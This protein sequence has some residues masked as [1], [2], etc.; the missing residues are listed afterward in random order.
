[1]PDDRPQRRPRSL[2]GEPIDLANM[3]SLGVRS[4]AV[5]CPTCRHET[6]LNVNSYP[7]NMTV[8]S[9]APRMVCTCCG[10]IGADARLNWKEQPERESLTGAQ[11]RS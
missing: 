2:P 7:D 10:T 11:W 4:L 3:C 9:F 1:M 8:P 6:V 5:S